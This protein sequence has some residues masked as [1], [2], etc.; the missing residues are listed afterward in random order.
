M[1]LLFLLAVAISADG[2]DLGAIDQAVSKC[3]AQVMTRTFAD[4]P[5]RRRAF[6]IAAFNEE[7]AIVEAREALAAERL[8]ALQPP[9]P[10]DPPAAA[11]ASVPAQTPAPADPAALDLQTK[12]LALR[13]QKLDDA[14]MLNGLRENALDLMRQQYVL[15]CS[16][17]RFSAQN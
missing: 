10:S 5:K 3:D 8:A 16:T 9:T 4:E 17:G 2:P 1:S 11:P 15:K 13:Q 12:A 6:A 7:Q 14:R